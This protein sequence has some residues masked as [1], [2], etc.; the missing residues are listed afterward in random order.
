VLLGFGRRP[1]TLKPLAPQR[2]A[3]IRSVAA[4]SPTGG[5]TAVLDFGAGANL[6]RLADEIEA[7]V[8]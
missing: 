8:G 6:E 1:V 7:F 3:F 2:L 4:T 5:S